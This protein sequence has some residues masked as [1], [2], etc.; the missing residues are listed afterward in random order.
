MPVIFPCA[1]AAADIAPGENIV[2]S[3]DPVRVIINNHELYFPDAAPYMDDSGRVKAPA[4]YIAEGLGASVAWDEESFT[5]FI[6]GYKNI[7]L[8]PGLNAATVDNSEVKLD[9]SAELINNRLYVPLRFIAETLG[10]SVQWDEPDRTV[11]IM[12]EKLDFPQPDNT[13]IFTVVDETVLSVEQRA[14]ID[15]VKLIKG[16]HHKDNLY[17]IAL[18]EKPNPGYGLEIIK[19]EMSWEQ[20]KVYVK[21]T[22]PDPDKMYAAVITYPYVVGRAVLPPYT[23][24]SFINVETGGYF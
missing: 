7:A 8:I 22:T 21:L 12:T 1:A 24:L 4:R 15:S 18:G 2:R 19:T 9:S 17:V 20:A 16:V 6:T 3:S 11:S 10:A 14:F 5:A 23:T 13:N